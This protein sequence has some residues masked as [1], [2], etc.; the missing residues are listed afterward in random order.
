M[1]HGK[2]L[3]FARPLID[4][5]QCALVGIIWMAVSQTQDMIGF[6]SDLLEHL[7][8]RAPINS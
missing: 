5:Y 8:Q 1:A 6:S 7:K 3:K 2:Q 4:L